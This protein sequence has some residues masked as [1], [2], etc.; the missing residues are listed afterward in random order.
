MAFMLAMTVHPEVQKRAQEELDAIIGPDRLPTF[1]DRDSLPY[2]NAILKEVARWQ[3]VIPLGIPHKST[4]DLTYKGYRIPA[5]SVII[6]N[7]WSVKGGA[8]RRMHSRLFPITTRRAISRDPSVYSD[9]ER[10]APERFLGSDGPNTNTRDT[11]ESQFGFGRRWVPVLAHRTSLLIH[12][13][14]CPGRHFA[15][16]ALFLSIASILHV[17]DIQPPIG[18]DGRPQRVEPK[19]NLDHA[20]A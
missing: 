12:H 14:I 4:E 17:F 2:I 5:G 8:A 10:F 6:P 18:P 1:E 19:I 15:V 13:S 20:L 11:S 16:D 9:P 7:I 3:P